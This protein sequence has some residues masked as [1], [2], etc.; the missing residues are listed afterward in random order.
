[1]VLGSLAVFAAYALGAW[2]RGDRSACDCLCGCGDGL[3]EQLRGQLPV[4]G[5]QP[6]PPRPRG[7]LPVR[8]GQPPATGRRAPRRG[9]ARFDSS[10]FAP[11]DR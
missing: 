6:F 1:M 5:G 10:A 9:P 8:G 11:G 7:Q 4:R 2:T 3:R